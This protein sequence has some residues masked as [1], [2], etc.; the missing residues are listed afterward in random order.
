[1]N[2]LWSNLYD[3]FKDARYGALFLASLLLSIGL[4]ISTQIFEKLVNDPEFQWYLL[5]ALR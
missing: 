1:M 5:R 3:R 2:S 4:L